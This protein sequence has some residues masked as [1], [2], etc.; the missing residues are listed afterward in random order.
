MSRA[1]IGTMVAVSLS[2]LA[3][4]PAHA[5]TIP[6]NSIFDPNPM[7]GDDG[8]C[9]LREAVR[10]ANNE[11]PVPDCVAGSPAGTD[12]VQLQNADYRLSN[13]TEGDVPITS[14]VTIQGQPGTTIDALNV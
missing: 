6:V 13:A 4:A 5:V 10:N 12:V 7:V 11:P 3:A 14:D 2:V 9:T 8:E 1:L